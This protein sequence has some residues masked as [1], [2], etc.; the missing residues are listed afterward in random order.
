MEPT[1]GTSKTHVP[2]HRGIRINHL[3][4]AAAVLHISVA[5]TI[6]TVG[7]L[8][9]MPNEFTEHGLGNFASDGFIYEGETTQLRDILK[10]QGI[11]AWATW[12]SQL[13]LR[14]YSLPLLVSRSFNILAIEP[15]NLIYFLSI[16]FLVYK[17]GETV[18]CAQSGLLAAAIV[19]LWPSF[20][21]HTTQP[22][23]DPFLICVFLVLIFSLVSSLNRSY[24]WQR[25]VLIGLAAASAVVVIRIVRLPMWG[26]ASA[27]V[28]LGALL[29]LV[30][31]WREKQVEWGNLCFALMLVSTILVVPKF[32]PWFRD[33][34]FVRVEQSIIPEEVQALPLPEQITQ[35]RRAFEVQIVNGNRLGSNAGSLIDAGVQFRSNADIVRYL[36]RAIEI[37]FF[38]P[39][40]NMWWTAGK[41]VGTSGRILAGVEMLVTYLLECLALIGVWIKRKVLA[42]WLL[43]FLILI[44]IIALGLIVVNIGS[45]YR[46]RYPFWIL[47]VVL[48]AGG[49]LS[50]TDKGIR[51][52]R[53][54]PHGV[55]D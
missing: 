30:R 15:V 40:P 47:L 31:M 50:L 6:F 52:P 2:G 33:Q 25:S 20:A 3:I 39:F 11:V 49:G 24:R 21:L 53:R 38:A 23:R 43:S 18:F 54:D 7:K 35:R 1:T 26:P 34:Q 46:L 41:Q 28:F 37:G 13:H 14:L 29:L 48:A 36:P 51:R 5:I 17:L 19:A 16:L 32:Q 27:A 55:S 9:L 4:I 22:L 8:R 45:L 44:G 42:V 12:P 10:S